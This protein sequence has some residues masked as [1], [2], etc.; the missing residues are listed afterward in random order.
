MSSPP[1]GPCEWCGGPQNWTF[2]SGVMYVRCMH[3]CQSIFPFEN[4]VLPP[5]SD[6]GDPNKDRRDEVM[7]PIGRGRVVPC[8]G[9]DARMSGSNLEKSLEDPPPGFLDTLWEGD[10][11]G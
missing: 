3:G 7:E 2:H 4:L 8:E 6:E 9:G 5:G 11:D 10:W 1:A